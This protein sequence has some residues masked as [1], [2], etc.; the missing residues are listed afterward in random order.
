MSTKAECAAPAAAH[1]IGM[2]RR[3]VRATGRGSSLSRPVPSRPLPPAPKAS[4]TP[5]SSMRIECSWPA[6]IA[7]T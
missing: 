4:A 6:A 3:E 5:L 7:C 2:P 1:A